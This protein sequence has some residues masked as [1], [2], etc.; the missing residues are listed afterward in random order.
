[1]QK[2]L[3]VCYGEAM[4][5]ESPA[6]HPVAAP[7]GMFR[8]VMAMIGIAVVLTLALAL[9]WRVYLHHENSRVPTDEPTLVSLPPQRT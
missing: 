6:G 4:L 2:I 7:T 8:R 1:M 9:M 5:E 3:C